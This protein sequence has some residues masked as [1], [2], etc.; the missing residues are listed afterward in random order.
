M[1]EPPMSY[2]EPPIL[3]PADFSMPAGQGLKNRS[4]RGIYKG[5]A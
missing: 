5:R 2:N 3:E 1:A 4:I